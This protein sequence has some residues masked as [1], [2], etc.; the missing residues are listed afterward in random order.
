MR[1]VKNWL[2][3]AFPVADLRPL[4]Y[5]SAAAPEIVAG[6]HA[7][8][9]GSAVH[10]L[11]V[12]APAQL[13]GRGRAAAGHRHDHA[14]GVGEP[15]NE[16]ALSAGRGAADLARSQPAAR[17]RAADGAPHGAGADLLARLQ[18]RLC[19]RRREEPARREIA[20]ADPRRAA[21]G[22]DPGLPVD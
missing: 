12:A 9:L 4:R 20:D 2:I 18:P 16:R 13:L 1:C 22:A 6:A 21:V 17:I 5:T 10:C 8:A 7:A 3:L 14:G 15:A 11:A 19:R